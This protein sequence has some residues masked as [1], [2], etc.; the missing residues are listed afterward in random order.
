LRVTRSAQDTA[1]GSCT[2]GAP[3]TRSTCCRRLLS[4]DDVRVQVTP[5]RTN[6]ASDV[7]PKMKPI[8]IKRLIMWLSSMPWKA[9]APCQG[10][11]RARG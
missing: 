3:H 11:L 9:A 4:K 5:A 1:G 7:Q 8:A 6:Q 10:A 2:C